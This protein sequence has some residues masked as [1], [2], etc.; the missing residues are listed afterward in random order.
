[1]ADDWNPARDWLVKAE[2]DLASAKLLASAAP[3]LRDTAIPKLDAVGLNP[4][5]R[6]DYDGVK[7][8]PDDIVYRRYRERP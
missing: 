2:N 8:L 7:E 6:Y 5:A 4:F 3:P 1:M